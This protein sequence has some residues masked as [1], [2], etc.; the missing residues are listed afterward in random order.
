MVVK[1]QVFAAVY[2]EKYQWVSEAERNPVGHLAEMD[3]RLRRAQKR[4]RRDQRGDED[5]FEKMHLPSRKVCLG[6]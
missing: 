5:S 3:G 6:Q 2:R 1:H 4:Q